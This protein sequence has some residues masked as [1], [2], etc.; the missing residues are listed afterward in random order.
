MFTDGAEGLNGWVNTTIL[1]TEKSETAIPNN[2][3]VPTTS[4]SAFSAFFIFLIYL[5]FSFFK[6]KI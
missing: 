3:T 2:I 5:P 6:I 4:D 1:K